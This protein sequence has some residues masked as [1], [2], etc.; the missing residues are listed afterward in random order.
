LNFSIAS[1]LTGVK[2]LIKFPSGSRNSKERFPHGIVVGG[3]T[4]AL[5][6]FSSKTGK[7]K[8]YLPTAAVEASKFLFENGFTKT[9]VDTSKMFDDR[10][11]KAYLAKV[12]RS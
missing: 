4:N 11:V 7:D 2:K 10:F 12:R 9:R 3:W 1:G 8:S 5:T 6:T